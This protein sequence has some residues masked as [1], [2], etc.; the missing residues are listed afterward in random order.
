MPELYVTK[1][2]GVPVDIQTSTKGVA[3]LDEFVDEKI[4]GAG[5]GT[6]SSV[7]GRTG[8]VI[9]TATDVKA[10]P[11]TTEIPTI[12]SVATTETDG[13]MSKEDKAKLDKLPIITFE[14]VGE[15]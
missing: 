13:L 3:G 4:S 2:D 10:L 8:A 11:D 1:I 6:V 7:N 14:K 15:V 12:P 9:L 5:A